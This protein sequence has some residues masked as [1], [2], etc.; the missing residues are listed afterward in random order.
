MF[1][2]S[3]FISQLSAN[4]QNEKSPKMSYFHRSE[5][6]RKREEQHLSSAHECR[7]QL[8]LLPACMSKSCTSATSEDRLISRWIKI[9]LCWKLVKVFNLCLCLPAAL[10][11]H[12]TPFHSL[13]KI[14]LLRRKPCPTLEKGGSEREMEQGG[15]KKKR[16]KGGKKESERERERERWEGNK[17]TGK[18]GRDWERDRMRKK[19][20]KGGVERGREGP[21]VLLRVSFVAEANC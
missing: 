15:M 17:E 1:E 16:K 3:A 7:I 18:W 5:K 19:Q 14:N 13:R 21:C 8:H 9:F 12:P 6:Q 11:H 10:W 4:L 2:V 20:E